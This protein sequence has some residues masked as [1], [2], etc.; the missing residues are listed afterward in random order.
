[1]G[2]T[3]DISQAMDED[4]QV[5]DMNHFIDFLRLKLKVGGKQSTSE[6]V[7]IEPAQKKVAITSKA[8]FGKRYLKYLTKKYLK[9]QDIN[10]YLRVIASDKTG[11]KVK[12]INLGDGGDQE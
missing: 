5:I 8:Q 3:I 2:Y 7:T 1:M 12:F 4:D 6:V 11:Y 10:T 9:K